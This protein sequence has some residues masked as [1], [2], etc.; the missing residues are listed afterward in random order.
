MPRP[1]L[2]AKRVHVMLAQPQVRKLKLLSRRT[3]MNVSEHIRR[4]VDAYIAQHERS[5]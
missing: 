1:K 3:G 2:E 4:A 5:E